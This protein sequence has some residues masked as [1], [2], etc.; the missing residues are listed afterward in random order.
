MRAIKQRE[1]VAAMRGE[2]RVVGRFVVLACCVP[3]RV[4]EGD[5]GA[6]LCM[7]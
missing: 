6:E 5:K 7:C 3:F 2:V 4:Q 1:G